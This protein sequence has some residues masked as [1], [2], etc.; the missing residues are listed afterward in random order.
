MKGDVVGAISDWVAGRSASLTWLEADRYVWSFFA[1]RPENWHSDPAGVA[2]ATSKAQAMLRSDVLEVS[3]TGPFAAGLAAAAGVEAVTEALASE[4]GR[5]VLA[6]TVDALDYALGA[7]TDLALVCPSPRRLL[8]GVEEVDF[9]AMDDVATALLEVARSVAGHRLAALVIVAS[10]PSEDERES[11][12]TMIQAAAHYGWASV[13]RLEGVASAA[14][15]AQLVDTD[16]VLLPD[17]SPAGLGEERRYGG[18][19]VR[20]FWENSAEAD[21]VAVDALARPFRFG[22]VPIQVEPEAVLRRL[23][24]LASARDGRI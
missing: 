13:A 11:W 9:Y 21:L 7:S 6:E 18:G 20:E 10:P 17:A 24:Q 8:G 12:S 14:G 5:R 22:Q 19:L 4:Q 16:L 2:A 1:G 3:L 15:P 23:D